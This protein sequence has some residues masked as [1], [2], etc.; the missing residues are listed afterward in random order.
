MS[1]GHISRLL[2]MFSSKMLPIRAGIDKMLVRIANRED[3][4]QTDLG[5]QCLSG[6]LAGI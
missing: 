2:I 1:H 6:F 5:L 4:D 3:P